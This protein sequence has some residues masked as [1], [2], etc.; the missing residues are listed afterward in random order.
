MTLTLRTENGEEHGLINTLP[1]SVPYDGMKKFAEKDRPSMEKMKKD[2][3]RLIKARY[4]NSRGTN[5]KLERPY[6]RW[7]G[8]AITMWKFLHNHIYELPKGLVDEVNKSPG[9]AK[10]SEICDVNGVPTKKDGEAEKIH[11]FYPI[12]F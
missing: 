9:L 6:C 7:A 11:Q 4:V 3:A 5:E 12:E 10:R 1:N 2:D 8:Q